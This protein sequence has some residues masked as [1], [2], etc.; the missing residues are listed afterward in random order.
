M[1]YE[2]VPQRGEIYLIDIGDAVGH[3]PSKV[4]P[5]VVI[6]ND[7]DNRSRTVTLVVLITSD[8]SSQSLPWAVH[9]EPGTTGLPNKSYVNC[10]HI[11]TLSKNHLKQK[12]GELP[13]LEMEK[14]DKAIL[15]I[16]GLSSPTTKPDSRLTRTNATDEK[17]EN[18][19]KLQK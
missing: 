3:G 12:V 7:C 8:S 16:L 5:C 11:Y 1:S 2:H 14:V 13:P 6:Q 10:G 18:V 19:N 9:L 4:R 17:I 15:Y